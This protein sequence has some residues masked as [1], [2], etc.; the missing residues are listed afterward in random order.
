MFMFNLIQPLG[1]SISITLLL[2]F[3]P[4]VFIMYHIHHVL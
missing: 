4:K 3:S 1:P 2:S